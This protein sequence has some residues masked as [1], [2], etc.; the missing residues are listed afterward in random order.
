MANHKN[1]IHHFICNFRSEK[2]SSY[3]LFASFYSKFSTNK[4][5]CSD[6]SYNN[7]YF[8][9]II[10]FVLNL[11]FFGHFVEKCVY[12]YTHIHVYTHTYV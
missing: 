3:F 10:A 6:P 11:Y 9:N 12:I 2:E 8:C 1:V 4:I 7:I 5:I